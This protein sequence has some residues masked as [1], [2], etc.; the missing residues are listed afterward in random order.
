MLDPPVT[1]W[2]QYIPKKTDEDR[3]VA[4]CILFPIMLDDDG[5]NGEIKCPP[6]P[7]YYRTAV[8]SEAGRQQTTGGKMIV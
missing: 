1:P 2:S 8:E 6:S 3:R 5:L 4:S 7:K